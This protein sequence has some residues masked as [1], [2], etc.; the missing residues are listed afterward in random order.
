MY[1]AGDVRI[2]NVPDAQLIEPTDALVRVTRAAICG[3]DLWPYK[4]MEP[5]ESG[6]RMGHEFIGV[7]EGV[8]ADVR[9]VERATSSSRRSCGRTGAACSAE[10]GY[11]A[12]AYTAA[13]T[14]STT[15]TADRGRPC[16]CRKPTGRSSFFRLSATTTLSSRRCS[17]SPT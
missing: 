10:K 8:G 1:G 6:R 11:T 13:G 3:S 12:S 7:V 17:R 4:A 15:S 5:T 14:A 2:E 16:E 9:S